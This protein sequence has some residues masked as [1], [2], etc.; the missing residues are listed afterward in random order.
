MSPTDARQSNTLGDCYLIASLAAIA[1]SDPDWVTTHVVTAAGRPPTDPRYI[2]TLFKD[3]K[4]IRLTVDPFKLSDGA[5]NRNATSG[6]ETWPAIVENA[7]QQLKGGLDEMPAGFADEALPFFTGKESSRVFLPD[8]TT[9]SGVDQLWTMLLERSQPPEPGTRFFDVRMSSPVVA[10]TK[11]D[12]KLSLRSLVGGRVSPD[13][14]PMHA[15]A[16]LGIGNNAQLGRFVKLYNPWGE[17][18]GRMDGDDDGVFRVP[19]NEF[20]RQF[21]WLSVSA[22]P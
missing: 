13:Y 17:Q 15:Y 20:L 3:G 5:K 10:T 14:V 22:A 2:V 7:F 1:V 18:D 8:L 12:N 19:L 9:R 4:P 16:I 11:Y 21:R 6:L